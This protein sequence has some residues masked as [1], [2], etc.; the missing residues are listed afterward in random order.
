MAFLQRGPGN[1]PGTLGRSQPE[2]IPTLSVSPGT[3]LI[4][5]N[6]NPSTEGKADR[7]R[8][9]YCARDNK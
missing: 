4:H 5:V 1:M 8:D 9:G 2:Y 3:R 6:D 7:S